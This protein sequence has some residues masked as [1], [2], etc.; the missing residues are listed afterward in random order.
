MTGTGTG[1][2]TSCDV[3]PKG[4]FGGWGMGGGLIS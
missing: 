4:F 1:V 3:I 2:M